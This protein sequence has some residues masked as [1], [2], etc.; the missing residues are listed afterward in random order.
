[1][2]IAVGRLAGTRLPGEKSGDTL[3]TRA[4]L[5][6]PMRA[7]RVAAT[8]L[9]VLGA[10][11]LP[12]APAVAEPVVPPD[13][14]A[15]AAAVA[16]LTGRSGDISA[17]AEFAVGAST[18]A[19]GDSHSCAL[20]FLGGL[21][22]WGANGSGQLGTDSTA[23]DSLV[24]VQVTAAGPLAGR[25][26]VQV[27]AGGAH[28]CV[29]DADGGVHCWGDNQYGQLGV[30]GSTD[31]RVPV[32]VP[33]LADVIKVATGTAHT[34]ALTSGGTVSCWG[35]NNAGQLGTNT[36][37]D[38]DSPQ[39]VGTLSGIVDIA[40]HEVGTCA[41]QDNGDAHCWG[42]NQDGQLGDGSL[43]P[44]SRVPVTVDRFAAGNPQ[45]RQIDVGR[46]HACALDDAGTAYCW[47]DDSVGQLGDSG[48]S[49]GSSVPVQVAAGG[50]TFALLDVGTDT[51]CA[52]DEQFSVSCWGRNAAGQ[53]GSGG[54]VDRDV[55]TTI[56]RGELT[57]LPLFAESRTL[58][59]E[60]DT[61]ARHTCAIDL[62]GIVYCWGAN[63]NGEFGDRTRTG[64]AVPARV[65]LGPA[66][67]TGLRVAAADRALRPGWTVPVDP[68][69][70]NLLGY[71]VSAAASSGGGA[72]CTAQSAAATTCTVTGLTN[73]T[74]YGVFV[75]AVSTA[76]FS[77]SAGVYA[78]PREPAG[79]G[80]GLLPVTGPPP[81]LAA[82]AV[83]L[84]IGTVLLLR[85]RLRFTA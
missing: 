45:F 59:V 42:D 83:L 74:R 11:L 60:V 48:P 44:R 57:G 6:T 10:A 84:T 31:S 26:L 37:P 85:R 54:T 13:A 30:G 14:R 9:I 32:A 64:S 8:L 19:T 4:L 80:A 28:T 1:M 40:A 61:N 15:I 24:P 3:M 67:I 68:G 58:L 79:E 34:C 65:S 50:R 23:A 62:F 52:T 49:S 7:G 18:I 43:D 39:S 47:G 17:A 55:P 66:P 21:W 81:Y 82:A 75:V 27:D 70:G 33:G 73:G 29:V 51:S 22:C 69:A 76:G 77:F 53:L 35:R 56:A 16:R 5:T 2:P 20:S 38:A 12:A 72:A 71:A 63:D 25:E 46:R 78:T 36:V 41:V